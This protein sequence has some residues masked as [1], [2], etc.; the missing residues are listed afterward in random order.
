MDRDA[1]VSPARTPAIMAGQPPEK[2]ATRAGRPKDPQARRLRHVIWCTFGR[3]SAIYATAGLRALHSR[4]R[5]QNN[6][7]RASSSPLA[8]L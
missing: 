4:E 2:S 7:P 5:V 1:G 6:D 8:F 3:E